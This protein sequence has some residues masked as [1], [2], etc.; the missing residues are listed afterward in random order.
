M[1]TG[2][3]TLLERRREDARMTREKPAE[4]AVVDVQIIHD[5]ESGESA[6]PRE[7]AVRRV[8]F[9]LRLEPEERE[10][11]V[12]TAL[13][14]RETKPAPGVQGESQVELA[15]WFDLPCFHGVAGVR[16]A[17]GLRGG[18]DRVQQG[19]FADS[20]RCRLGVGAVSVVTIF[21]TG[22]AAGPLFERSNPDQAKNETSP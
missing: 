11:A 10:T 7:P 8:L 16:F 17:G 9:A 13:P 14:H 22:R 19:A 21:V 12:D 18:R 20:G 3:A 5:L 15:A 4:L 2:L 1:S 6:E